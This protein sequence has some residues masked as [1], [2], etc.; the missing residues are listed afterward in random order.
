MSEGQ[1]Q[2]EPLKIGVLLSGSGSN[3]Q[4]IIN[5]IESGTLNAQIRIVIASNP[6]AYGLERAREAGIPTYSL[7][8]EMYDM[9]AVANSLIADELECSEVELVVMAGYM[10]KLGKEVLNKFPDRVVNLHPALLPSFPGAHAIEDA[11]TAGVKLT[12][13]TVHFANE[14]YDKGPIIAQF[15]VPVLDGDDKESL[16]NRIHEVEHVIYPEV[17]NLIAQDKVRINEDSHVEIV[18]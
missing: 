12:G 13:V 3:L 18:D 5:A 1:G 7:S 9:P 8:R 6:D 4:A 17:I 10:R 15:S 2:F 16:A 11:L 14:E